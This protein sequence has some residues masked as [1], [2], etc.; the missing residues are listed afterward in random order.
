MSQVAVPEEDI[1]VTDPGWI[2]YFA[3]TG[4]PDNQPATANPWLGDWWAALAV[5]DDNDYLSS[6]HEPTSS[7]YVTKLNGIVNPEDLDG[8]WTMKF[9]AGKPSG[10]TG[11]LNLTVQLRM[12]YTD[13]TDDNTLGELLAEM[14]VEDISDTLTD[15]EMVVPNTETIGTGDGLYFRIIADYVP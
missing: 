9:R 8:D 7:V 12:N 6:P 11:Q 13:E 15:Y 2:A 10:I 1:I 14:I 4:P 3:A 5:Q